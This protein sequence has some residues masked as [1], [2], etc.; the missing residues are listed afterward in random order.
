MQRAV[1]VE[2]RSQKGD[3]LAAAAGGSVR[4]FHAVACVWEKVETG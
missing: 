1:G 2:D 4:F 3:D